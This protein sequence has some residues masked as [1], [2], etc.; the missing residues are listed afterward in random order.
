MY[1]TNISYDPDNGLLLGAAGRYSGSLGTQATV[2]P[3][4]NSTAYALNLTKLAFVW[5]GPVPN[6]DFSYLGI[7]NGVAYM[8]TYQGDIYVA[9]TQTGAQLKDINAGESVTSA[10]VTNGVHGRP[11]LVTVGNSIQTKQQIQMEL[12]TPSGL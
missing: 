6:H 11:G 1:W 12:F 4:W 5:Q 3:K 8:A 7:A 9:N 10:L 2:G